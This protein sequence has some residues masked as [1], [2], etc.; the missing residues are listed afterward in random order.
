MKV[1]LSSEAQ[2]SGG[3]GSRRDLRPFRHSVC[4]SLGERPFEDGRHDDDELL[5]DLV[6]EDRAQDLQEHRGGVDN[7]LRDTSDETER[8]ERYRSQ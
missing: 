4:Q 3:T 2:Q 6:D 8:R 7:A 5:D 1:V